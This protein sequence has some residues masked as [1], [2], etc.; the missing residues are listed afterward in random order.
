M[1]VCACVCT[2][3]AYVCVRVHD[4]W[5]QWGDNEVRN[6]MGLRVKLERESEKD[7]ERQERLQLDPV[8]STHGS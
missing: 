4:R 3:G 8:S 5:R 2:W 1:C 6:M 7:E